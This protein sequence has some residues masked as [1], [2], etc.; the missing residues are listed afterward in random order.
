MTTLL[1]QM[2]LAATERNHA[3]ARALYDALARAARGE[4]PA[5]TDQATVAASMATLGLSRAE[6][7]E[8]IGSVAEAPVVVREDDQ[9]ERDDI[10]GLPG[11]D[12]LPCVR[13][14]SVNA[15]LVA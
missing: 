12:V 5:E 8:L 13:Q 1:E 7:P 10:E 9:L 3:A 11:R 2:E 6:L 4:E 14:T 15:L